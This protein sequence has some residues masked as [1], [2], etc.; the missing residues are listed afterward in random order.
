MPGEDVHHATSEMWDGVGAVEFD[1]FDYRTESVHQFVA[2]EKKCATCHV[3]MTAFGE[4]PNDPS[5]KTG[6]TFQPRIEACMQS[7]CHVDGL[8]IPEGSE[9]EFDH[10]GRQTFTDS[11]RTV[12]ADLLA[13]ASPEDS[14]SE[15]F[16]Q[17]LFNLQFEESA[18][19]DGVHNPNYAE[20]ILVSTIAVWRG[21]TSVEPTPTS[22]AGIPTDFSLHQNYPNPFN[23]TTKIRFDVPRSS[24]VKLIMY[25]SLGQ[26]VETLV[27]ETLTPNSYE[28][29]FNAGG[30]SS[31]LYF[32]K[33]I[34]DNFV[35]TKKMLL[36]K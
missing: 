27:D 31:G 15:V 18:R 22:D 8:D 30:H 14:M 13:N 28:I 23:P 1:G 7:G 34:S 36:L 29:E 12:L 26:A 21:F 35:T 9:R 10:R 20:D 3:F 6:H 2:A 16:S 5:A 4:D 25:N 33:L 32:Y 19:S 11:L 17:A 24:H